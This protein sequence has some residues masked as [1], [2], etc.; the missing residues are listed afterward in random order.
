MVCGGVALYIACPFFHLSEALMPANRSN[1]WLPILLLVI[2]MISTCIGASVAKSLFPVI[3]A[4]GA[5]AMRLGFG[6][7]ILL[8]VFRPWR[9][10]WNSLPWTMLLG[11]GIALGLMNSLFYAAINRIPLGIAVA[12]EFSGPLALAI[13]GSRR[14]VD[15]IW[16]ALAVGGL[17][18][19][20]PWAQTQDALDPVG[21]LLALAAG[22][23]WALYILF[24]RKAGSDH[25]SQSVAIGSF[26]AALVAVPWGFY[27]VGGALF[28]PAL[29]PA[30]IG[31][32][33]L[34]VA[35]PYTLEM[36]AL[37]RV[38]ASTF[39][40]LMS[41]EPAV[42]ALCGLVLLSE[43]LTGVQWLAIAAVMVASAGTALSAR[44]TVAHAL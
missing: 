32:A 35:V 27:N 20:V 40:L 25:G 5:V 11:Y 33:V 43:Q 36:K 8:A 38:P 22:G 21:I 1:T 26:F 4:A 42:A 28:S 39:G 15:F 13:A 34:A 19:L 17:L 3:G 23:C 2:A 44:P 6:A 41:L 37:T 14:L 9:A 7:L 10:R 29:L 12:V 30:G 24:G 31:L 16:V 18:L